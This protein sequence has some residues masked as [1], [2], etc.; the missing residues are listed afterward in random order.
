MAQEREFIIQ[1]VDPISLLGVNNTKLGIIKNHFPSLKIIA[2]GEIIK[3][4]GEHKEIDAFADR[5]D[6]MLRHLER[7]N[8]LTEGDIHNLLDSADEFVSGSDPAVLVHG[9]K[10][11]R[12]VARTPGH[13]ELVK[14]ARENDL[15]LVSGPA[16][17][18]KT[19]TAVALAVRAL[20]D[21][22][23]RRIVLTRPAVE[24]GESLGFLPGDMKDKLDPYMQPIYDAL[25][26]MIPA[27]RLEEYL[28]NRTVEIAPLAYMRGRTLDHA[29]VILDEAQNTTEN[30]MKMFLTR[31]GSSAKF[32]ITGDLTQIDL[33]NNKAS[34]LVM[35]MK[36]LKN[37]EGI[38]MIHLTSKD[39]VRHRLVK[40]IVKAFEKHG[41]ES[42]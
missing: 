39:I 25:Y 18:G 42:R 12:I 10:G 6:E 35:A 24:A 33:P 2:R 14:S 16:G 38:G 3:V 23:V 36:I 11:L 40:K 37:I 26:D 31:M 30:Q 34:G 8:V 4:I 41:D 7:Y 19:Y 29:F 1:G 17:S 20:K 9:N 28:E 21:K 5:Y 13:H 22:V 32:V 27:K 15:V